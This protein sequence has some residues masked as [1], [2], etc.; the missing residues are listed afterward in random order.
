MNSALLHCSLLQQ[1]ML[2]FQPPTH[3]QLEQPGRQLSTQPHGVRVAI[4][5]AL[6]QMQH[7]QNT[8]HA[9]VH[10]KKGSSLQCYL[11]GACN[12]QKP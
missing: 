4:K 1:I 11:Q 12:P 5:T 3:V 9:S 8:E 6:W 2:A 7:A 10:L